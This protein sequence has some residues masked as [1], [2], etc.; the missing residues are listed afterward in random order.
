MPNDDLEIINVNSSNQKA[1]KNELETNQQ[2]NDFVRNSNPKNVINKSRYHSKINQHIVICSFVSILLLPW[3][4]RVVP[5]VPK[6]RPK[7]L[8]KCQNGPQ[9]SSRVAK[10]APRISKR[11][12]C[13]PQTT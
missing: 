13:Q 8:R 10:M 2:I 7:V 6:W 12:H 3:S 1:T 9:S 4:S 11:S 5:E